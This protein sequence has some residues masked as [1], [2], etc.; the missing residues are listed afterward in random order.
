LL[1]TSV[2]AAI[3]GC[4]AQPADRD[5]AAESTWREAIVAN[6]TAET[7]CF[8][9]A[10][11]DLAWQ[12]VQC[13]TAPARAFTVGDGSDYA[14]LATGL[15]SQS[16]GT[17]P[18]V[19][20]MTSEKD[21]GSPS[22]YSLQLNSNFMSGTAACAGGGSDCLSWAQFVYSSDAEAV[23]IQNWLIFYGDTC[24]NGLW[25]PD[26]AGDCFMNSAGV[27]VP[28]IPLTADADLSSLKMSGIAKANGNDT[29]VFADGTDAYVTSEPD[30]IT[31]LASAWIASEY[32][33]FGD[34]GGTEAIFNKSTAIEV[35]I[36]AKDGTTTAP[37][38]IDNA[39]TT[40]ETNNRT[41]GACTAAGGAPPSIEFKETGTATATN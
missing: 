13:T 39:G 17:F 41:L 9:A 23:F 22:S 32:N 36:E 40:A 24:P 6:P 21:S 33:I 18:H 11:P 38:C 26:G 31:D 28:N 5:A 25:N 27:T 14:L 12:P 34:G 20:G 4:A 15:I 1:A 37:S 29:L 16:V 2:F 19:S 30:S 8:H 3:T 10:Y 7:G 35:R